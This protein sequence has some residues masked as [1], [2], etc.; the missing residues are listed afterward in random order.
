MLDKHGLWHWCMTSLLKWIVLAKRF[1]MHT[2]LTPRREWALLLTLA[3]VQFTHVLD[4]MI[5]M[6]LGPQLTALFGISLTEFGLLVSAYTVAAGVSGLFAT[7]FVDRFDR[8]HLL[9]T[10]YALFALTTVACGVNTEPT[11]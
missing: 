10:L 11:T 2:A 7:T 5:M 3:G 6:P 8:K 4:F 9:L 1:G